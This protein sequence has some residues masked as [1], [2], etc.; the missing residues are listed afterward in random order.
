MA[1]KPPN[2]HRVLMGVHHVWWTCLVGLLLEMQALGDQVRVGKNGFLWRVVWW[3]RM[4]KRAPMKRFLVGKTFP[5]APVTTQTTALANEQLPF[6]MLA[7]PPPPPPLPPLPPVPPSPRARDISSRRKIHAPG[8]GAPIGN[9]VAAENESFP[10]TTTTTTITITPTTT[11]T[12][13]TAAVF[14]A[15]ASKCCLQ[16]SR[17]GGG[18][19]GRSGHHVP[20]PSHPR[21]FSNHLYHHRRPY[22]R[23]CHHYRRGRSR[24]R[25]A[26][27]DTKR[28]G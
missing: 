3:Q 22:C 26:K 5:I 7:L 9:A 6:P 21:K 2:F 19:G 1:E 13:T 8:H 20:P 27:K 10:A 25:R 23:C 11:T 15:L 12:T 18:Y 24:R 28:Y 14:A 4:A 17:E 16:L